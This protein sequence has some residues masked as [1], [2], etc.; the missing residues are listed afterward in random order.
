MSGDGHGLVFIVNGQRYT[1]TLLLPKYLMQKNFV[2]YLKK[3][4]KKKQNLCP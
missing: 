4:K 3:K 1:D 2:I